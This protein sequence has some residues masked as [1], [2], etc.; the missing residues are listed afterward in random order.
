MLIIMLT[1]SVALLLACAM[2]SSGS[3][4]LNFRKEMVRNLFTWP[5]SSATTPPPRWTFN[6]AKAAEETLLALR[7]E[8]NIIGACVYTRRGGVFRV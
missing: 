4:R 7:A 1:S 2:R 6:D 5:Q 3:R 8:P